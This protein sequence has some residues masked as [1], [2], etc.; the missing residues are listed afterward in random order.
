MDV[1]IIKA[2]K[3]EVYVVVNK[4][5]KFVFC[6]IRKENVRNARFFNSDTLAV[7]K[8][9]AFQYRVK[10][11]YAFA[12]KIVV[13]FLFSAVCGTES[14]PMGSVFCVFISVD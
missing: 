5:F 7:N 3:W 11:F 4:R 12:Q 14:V 6:T 2:E 13:C 1:A 9:D 8:F 10:C